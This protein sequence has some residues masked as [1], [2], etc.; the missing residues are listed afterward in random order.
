MSTFTTVGGGLSASMLGGYLS[1]KLENKYP[2]IKGII[3]G[4]GAIA[5]IPFMVFTFFI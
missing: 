4:G 5:A 3:S 2:S 1:D